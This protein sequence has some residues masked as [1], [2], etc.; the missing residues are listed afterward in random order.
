MQ[1][2]KQLDEYLNDSLIN[3]LFSSNIPDACKK[4]P[5][6]LGIDEAGRGPVLGPMVY[7]VAY[8]P[9]ASEEVLKGMKFNDSKELTETNREKLFEAIQVERDG[10]QD[11]GYVIKIVSPNMI[12]NSMLRR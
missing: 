2:K 1:A 12:S 3:K 6:I 5:C 10:F 4:G 9:R 7:A 11:L 8:Y